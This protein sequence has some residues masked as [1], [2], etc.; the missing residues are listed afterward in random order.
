MKLVK[1]FGLLVLSVIIILLIALP[2]EINVNKEIVIKQDISIVFEHINNLKNWEQ[3][4]PWQK[5]DPNVVNSYSGAESGV[6]AVNSYSSENSDVG[7]GKMKI[8]QS[9]ENS[10]VELGIFMEGM[11]DENNPPSVL[12]QIE[13]IKGTDEFKTLINNINVLLCNVK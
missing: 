9:I 3:W 11:S 5:L 6:G 8:L 2:T 4:S 10:K 12:E 7:I 13:A 1:I